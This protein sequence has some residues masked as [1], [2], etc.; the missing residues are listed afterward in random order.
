MRKY[1]YIGEK[2]CILSVLG[3]L[4]SFTLTFYCHGDFYFILDKE[5]ILSFKIV[6]ILKMEYGFVDLIFEL[7]IADSDNVQGCHSSLQTYLRLLPLE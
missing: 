4:K 5:S 6:S 3:T 7:K 1:N 2:T